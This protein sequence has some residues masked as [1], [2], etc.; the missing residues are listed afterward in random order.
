MQKRNSQTECEHGQ[1]MEQTRSL[2]YTCGSLLITTPLSFLA[3]ECDVRRV[4][5][6]QGN[7]AA[8][9]QINVIH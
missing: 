2:F 9:N 6:G 5:H 8:V 3:N 1:P 7:L 4:L